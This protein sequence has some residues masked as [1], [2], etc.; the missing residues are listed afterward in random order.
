MVTEKEKT[1][2][3]HLQKD[4]WRRCGQQDTSTAGVRWRWKHR[5]EPGGEEWSVGYVPPR[6]TKL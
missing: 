5:T 2:K 6:A 3:K 1:T 4:I